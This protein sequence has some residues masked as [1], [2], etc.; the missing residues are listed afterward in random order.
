V[1]DKREWGKPAVWAITQN[2]R[3]WTKFD[4]VAD[5]S[6]VIEWSLGDNYRT[7]MMTPGDRVVFW[8]TGSG[9]GIA[10]IG[11]VLAVRATP[12][13]QWKDASGRRHAAPFTGQ[14]FLPPFPNRRYIHRSVTAGD[15]RMADCELIGTAAQR[16]APLRIETAEWKVIERR[17]LQFDRTNYDFRAAWS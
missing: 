8:I 7:E 15:P 10:R 16:Q 13:G 14:F 5:R 17:L 6:V 2:E 3:L 4:A 12:T 9:G 1:T 11:F